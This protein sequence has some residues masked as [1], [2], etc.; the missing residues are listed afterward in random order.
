LSA[1][2]K[3]GTEEANEAGDADVGFG[4]GLAARRTGAGAELG[5]EG[6]GVVGFRGAE[7]E[8]DGV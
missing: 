3:P 5:G 4:R 7:E 1:P 6:T 8:R 2:R